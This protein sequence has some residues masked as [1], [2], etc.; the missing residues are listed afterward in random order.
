[1]REDGLRERVR[2]HRAPDEEAAEQRA[3]QVVQGAFAE[4]EHEPMPRRL[5]RGLVAAAASLTLLGAAFTPPGQAVADWVHD[6]VTPGRE[7]ARQALTS[8]P[9]E[10]RLL[11]V[12]KHG[13]WIVQRDG[14]KRLLGDYDDA[15]WSPG[16]LFV[17]AT[18]GRELVALDPKG[19]VRWSIARPGLAR[20]PRWSPD[21]FRV[22]YRSGND[23]RVVAGDGTGDRLIADRVGGVAPAWRPNANHELSY[24]ERDGRVRRVQTDTGNLASRSVP[25]PVPSEL[26]WSADGNRLLALAPREWRLL[27]ARGHAVRADTLDGDAHI[28]AAAFSPVGD[29]F[30]LVSYSTSVNRSRLE[31]VKPGASVQP[32]FSGAGRFGELVWAPDGRWLLA[33]WQDADQWLFIRTDAAGGGEIERLRAVANI[34]RQFDPGAADGSD[35]PALRTWCCVQ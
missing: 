26:A 31:L 11:V 20:D 23:L 9:A 18:R 34:S 8:L 5:R 15:S 1:M 12:S 35:F 27:D 32:L 19:R 6:A 33:A 17:I 25:G 7:H 29:T 16:G 22:A 24:V 28:L 2:D 14:S 21:G 3:W 4:H 10:G 30:A 13:P